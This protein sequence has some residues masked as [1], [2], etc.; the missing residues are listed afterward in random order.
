[1][2][3]DKPRRKPGPARFPDYERRTK[4]ITTRWAAAELKALDVR[5]ADLDLPWT[6]A[7][8]IRR[9]ALGT[10]DKP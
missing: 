9:A 5:M 8:F 7:E 4:Q 6:R 3:A 1:M 2:T 10:L